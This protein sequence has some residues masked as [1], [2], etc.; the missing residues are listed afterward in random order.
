MW[1]LKPSDLE[2]VVKGPAQVST[3]GTQD[4]KGHEREGKMP[5]LL[6]SM[7]MNALNFC[8]FSTCPVPDSGAHPANTTLSTTVSE[9]IVEPGLNVKAPSQ[10]TDEMT[11]MIPSPESTTPS[12]QPQPILLASPNGLDS[13]GIDIF[14]IPSERRISQI[15]SV[16]D[17]KIGMVMALNLSFDTTQNRL[18]LI[19]GYEDGSVAVHEMTDMS[20]FT[21]SSQKSLIWKWTQILNSRPHGQPVLSL[22]VTPD[23]TSF[24]TS[25]ADAII[26]KFLMP[27]TTVAEVIVGRSS[28]EKTI[29]TKHAGQQDL[30]V[31]SDGKIFVTAGWDGSV[32]VY[33]VKTCKE[34][35]VL[36]W[37]KEGCYAVAFAQILE[38]DQTEHGGGT[39]ESAENSLLRMNGMD[40]MKLERDRKIHNT[41]WI[42]AGSKDGKISLWDIY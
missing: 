34:L 18:L 6:H 15:R 16:K 17:T 10:P 28:P 29:N 27:L 41:H 32:R 26:A 31:R 33:S 21:S 7:S 25:S 4:G 19:S 24:I 11:D 36:Q 5:W 39:N 20:A 12:R 1:E 40:K 14:H 23:L 3:M 30:K 9:D 37:H 42:V 13:S 35:A 8:A 2:G 22:D 38:E